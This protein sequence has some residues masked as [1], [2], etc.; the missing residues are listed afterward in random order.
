MRFESLIATVLVL[1]QLS[2]PGT[3]QSRDSSTSPRF[4]AS[5]T[6]TVGRNELLRVLIETDPWLVREILDAV[7]ERNAKSSDDF[8]ARALGGIDRGKNPDIVSATRTAAASLEWIELLRRAR[9]ENEAIRGKPRFEPG[10][11]SAQGSVEFFEM[12]KRGKQEKATAK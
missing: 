4:S 2:S 3:A 12:L 5:E 11:R 9:A 10:G 7:A 1:S 8:V 6:R